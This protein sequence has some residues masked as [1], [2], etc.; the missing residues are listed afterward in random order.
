MNYFEWNNAIGE[1]YFNTTNA[2]KEVHLFITRDDII[3]IGKSQGIQIDGE[4]IFADYIQAIIFG[5]EPNTELQTRFN[6][7][8]RPLT[9]FEEWNTAA[10]HYEEYPYYLAFL[11][12]YVLPLTTNVDPSYNWNN[13]YDRVNAFFSEY[14]IIPN[15]QAYKIGTSNFSR[16]DPLWEDLQDWSFDTRNCELGFFELHAFSNKRWIYVGKPLSQCVVPTY[17]LIRLPFL[18]EEIGIVPG[19]RI[20]EDTF[21]KIIKKHGKSALGLKDGA[22]NAVRDRENELGGSIIRIIQKFYQDWKGET[23]FYNKDTGITNRGVTIAHLRL[24]LEPD[25]VNGVTEVYFRLNSPKDY[26]DDLCFSE[27]LVCKHQRSGYSKPLKVDFEEETIIEDSYNKWKAV[28]PRKEVRVLMKGE[29]FYLS[30]WIEVPQMSVQSEMLLVTHASVSDSIIDW[31]NLMDA[32]EFCELNLIGLPDEFRVFK[33]KAPTIDHPDFPQLSFQSIKRIKIIGG[34]RIGVRRYLEGILPEIELE[35]GRGDEKLLAFPEE[36]E[37]GFMLTK[38]STDR[39]IWELPS[40][41]RYNVKYSLHVEGEKLHQSPSI[42]LVTNDG[43]SQDYAEFPLPRRD[44]FGEI[45]SNELDVPHKYAEGSQVIRQTAEADRQF[46]LRK[47]PYSQFFQPFDTEL[48]EQFS[49]SPGDDSFDHLLLSFLSTKVLTSVQEYWEVFDTIYYNRFNE[50]ETESHLPITLLK[51]WSLNMLDYM[52]VLDYDYNSGKIIVNPPQL[53]PIPVTGGRKALLIGGRTPELLERLGEETSKV[54]YVLNHCQQDDSLKAFLLPPTITVAGFDQSNN[55]DVERGIKVIADS[56]GLVYDPG[57][58]VQFSL[59]QFS[60]RINEYEASLV[61]EPGYNDQGWSTKVFHPDYLKFVRANPDS[62]DKTY[63]LIEYKRN[64]HDYI[65]RLWKD[66]VAYKVN[67]NWGRFLVLQRH[68]RHVIL[69]ERTEH[70]FNRI[71]VPATLPLPRLIAESMTLFSGRAPKRMKFEVFG[72]LR[73]YNIY[74]NIPH[75]F[76][77]NYFRLVGQQL[78]ETKLD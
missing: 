74:E 53:V 27:N 54:G 44:R 68:K 78:V 33:L 25:F 71:A 22:V 10:N 2:E 40:G 17:V 62:I 43:Y 38:K 29:N 49:I 9:L 24:C 52:G 57:E 35:N 65:H 26:P 36:G 5:G 45:L 51:R 30:G 64:E 47:S 55:I 6:L 58:Y 50:H 1:Y 67:K 76:A 12:L 4:A 20:S 48:Q 69:N 77:F 42:T 46:R 34:V 66:G 61:P 28:L 23:D 21:R 63:T 60:G 11:S 16:L 41:I 70:D 73:W 14:H 7:I 32:A 37:N 3:R 19:D 59:A 15:T 56:C 39:P 31:G 8:E 13:Y 72:R 18:F 75:I